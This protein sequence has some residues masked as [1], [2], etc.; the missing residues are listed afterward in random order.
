MNISWSQKILSE[1]H[2]EGVR[3]IV[4]CPGARNSPLVTVLSHTRGF[5]T[6]SFFEERSG[7]FF[8]LGVARRSGQPVAIITTSGTAVAELLPATIEAFHTGVP[9]ILITAD[10]PRRLRGTGAPQSIDQMGLFSKFVHHEFDL[11]EGEM[12]SL[13][14]WSRRA[15]VQVNVCF[16]EPLIDENIELLELAPASAIASFAGQSRFA[17]TTGLEWAVLRLT[18]FLR[19]AGTLVVV[20]GTLESE[21]ERDAV[22]KF[23]KQVGA[24]VYLEATSGLRERADLQEISLRSGD[25]LLAWGLKRQLFS[26]VLRLGGVPTVR[27]WRDL[28]EPDSAIEVFSLSSLPFAGL[29]RGEFVCCD[30]PG[31]LNTIVVM[32]EPNQLAGTLFMK[33]R[34]AE[35]ILLQLFE[36]EPHAEPSLVR[37]ISQRISSPS[38]VYVGNSLPIREW[39][40]AASHE[41]E[42][43]V[44]ANRGVNGIDGQVATFLGVARPGVDNWAIIGDLTALYDLAGPWALYCRE[45]LSARIVVIN[46]GGGKIFS[47]IFKNDLFENRHDLNFEAWAKLWKLDYQKWTHVPLELGT[48]QLEIIELVPDVDSTRRFWDRYDAIWS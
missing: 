21:T 28:D 3:D 30:I 13:D 39:D 33:D 14:T 45:A 43:A 46:N 1:L 2:R 15:P 16:D 12:F 6:H 37:Q 11:E 23:L 41:R 44:E 47:R 20:V 29:S 40:L 26:R 42:F 5:D 7:A 32:P 4:V 27:I 9:L 38:L 25:Q 17:T 48:S 31:T 35:S 18:K 24:P 8:A 34:A 36:A 19:A 10:R 22:A